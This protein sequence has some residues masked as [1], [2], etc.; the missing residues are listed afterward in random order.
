MKS[1]YLITDVPRKR[2]RYPPRTVQFDGPLEAQVQALV[3]RK[4]KVS[5]LVQ[6][7][8]YKLLFPG[9]EYQDVVAALERKVNGR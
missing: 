2:R 6:L 5:H 9:D 1:S 4:V 7:A 8:M 3:R